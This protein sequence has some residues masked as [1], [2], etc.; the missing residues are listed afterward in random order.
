MGIINSTLIVQACNFLVCYAILKRILL[1]ATTNIIIK[2][3]QEKHTINT[4]IVNIQQTLEKESKQQA[5]IWKKT[6]KILHKEQPRT[7]ASFF[8][9][10][11]PKVFT[12]QKKSTDTIE[13]QAIIKEK[14]ITYSTE[15][16]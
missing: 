6:H 12:R 2:N 1:R 4:G 8:Y 16:K 5:S 13:L 3:E 7:K 14:I 10:P 15:R 11:K 9:T